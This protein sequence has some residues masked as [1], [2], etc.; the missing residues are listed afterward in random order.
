M[1]KNYKTDDLPSPLPQMIIYN[2][3]TFPVEQVP[4]GDLNLFS[5]EF[6]VHRNQ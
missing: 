1:V 5:K 3:K 4:F 6:F 2:F